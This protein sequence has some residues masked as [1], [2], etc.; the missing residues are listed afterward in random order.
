MHTPISTQL[1]PL[2]HTLSKLSNTPDDEALEQLE[3][4]RLLI[5]QCHQPELL[6]TIVDTIPS[7]IGR[8]SSEVNLALVQVAEVCPPNQLQ[9]P[10]DIDS[11]PWALRLRWLRL[12]LTKVDLETLETWEEQTLLRVVTGWSIA[13]VF[14]PEA[15]LLRCV[16]ADEPRLRVFALEQL[17]EAVIGLGIHV[18][19][20]FACLTPLLT[21]EKVS[22][23]KRAISLLSRGWLV[24]LSTKAQKLRDSVLKTALSDPS[25]K[26]VEAAVQVCCA[27]RL[28][29]LLREVMY[30]DVDDVVRACVVR[31]AGAFAQ[32]ED[33]SFVLTLALDE[34]L[35]YAAAAKSFLLEAHRHGV[36]LREEHLTDM[37]TFFDL[38]TLWEPEAWNRVMYIARKAALEELMT[39]PL[40]DPRWKRRVAL[41]TEQIDASIPSFLANS[42]SSI[43]DVELAKAFLDVAARHP[44]FVDVSTC[45]KWLDEL[46]RE[47]MLLLRLKGGEESATL[48]KHYIDEETR[49]R[50]LRRLGMS[51]LWSL[52]EDR[53]QLYRGWIE[54]FG[55][56][57]MGLFRP[58]LPQ[59][60]RD[61]VAQAV[62][63]QSWEEHEDDK[64]TPMERLRVFCKS[65][66]RHYLKEVETLFRGIFAS[67]V[68]KA[69][70]GDFSIKRV[71]IPEL[72]QM[73]FRYGRS[74]IQNGWSVRRWHHESPET[75]KDLLWLFVLDWLYE[76]PSA[77]MTVALL[78]VFVR[79]QPTGVVLRLI[80]PYWRH[81]HTNVQRAALEAII[82]GGEEA[83][84]LELSLCQLTQDTEPR[85]V[86][87]ALRALGVFQARWAE[88][89][90]TQA[91]QHP[92]M[93]VKKEAAIALAEV[94]SGQSVES[95]VFWLAYHDNVSFRSLLKLALEQSAGEAYG[96]VLLKAYCEE[97]T[98]RR[99]D[100]L[101]QAMDGA[102]RTSA[103]M[104]L[105]HKGSCD[106]LVEDCLQ[107][108]VRLSDASHVEL[109]RQLY[110]ARLLPQVDLDDPTRTMRLD[111]FSPEAARELLEL[112]EKETTH[113]GNIDALIREQFV[114][115]LAWLRDEPSQK[116]AELLLSLAKPRHKDL[117]EGLLD[118]VSLYREDLSLEVIF[119]FLR[120]CLADDKLPLPLR[121]KGLRLLRSLPVSGDMTGLQRYELLQSLGGVIELSDLRV[122]LATCR[123]APD[124]AHE[125]FALLSKAFSIP[126]ERRGEDESLTA[127]REEAES[128]YRWEEARASEWLEHTAEL[129]PLGVAVVTPF[130]DSSG[131]GD[132]SRK[133][134]YDRMV[135][136]LREG[137]FQERSHAAEQ[138]LSWPETRDVW[139]SLLTLYLNGEIDLRRG[140]LLKLTDCVKEWPAEPS[141][142]EAAEFFLPHIPKTLKRQ[143]AK[144]WLGVWLEGNVEIAPYLRMLPQEVLLPLCAEC[145]SKGHYQAIRLLA[146]DGSYAIR[147][148]LDEVERHAPEE[149]RSLTTLPASNEEEEPSLEDDFVDPIEG[150]SVDGLATLIREKSVEQGLAVRGIHA[151]GRH[152]ERGVDVLATFVTDPRPQVRSA[153]RRA[154][155]KHASRE[156]VLEAA[157]QALRMETRKDVI[158]SLMRTLGHRRYEPAFPLLLKNMQHKQRK[159]QQTARHLLLAWGDEIVPMVRHEMRRARPDVRRFYE[160]FLDELSVDEADQQP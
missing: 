160:S 7:S 4:L 45:T 34:P 72:E 133:E 90:A 19:E 53:G 12:L 117:F 138:L 80:E 38:Y 68:K 29:S 116:R 56:T 33:L 51:T 60:R 154:L 14:A 152:G 148:L 87:Q 111:G 113:K 105:A 61:E 35:V 24:G 36:F 96:A 134:R 153:A 37:L 93:A 131:G 157:T 21:D 147:C 144:E 118:I 44:F 41:L 40:H 16:R 57:E 97:T 135:K 65:G 136:L 2:L 108:Y 122:C 127:L 63:E 25:Q 121:N 52:C 46:P 70:E 104:R 140:P 126:A 50:S 55:P 141:K 78:E 81:S 30:D 119:S 137:A 76:Q 99:R 43:C 85:I 86:T 94:G 77:A 106:E 82:E 89:Y 17:E 71:C 125:T 8:L 124:V 28:G 1:Q 18:D 62:L 146:L 23:R 20:A 103:I 58:F 10:E 3:A 32:D 129:R 66:E 95:L 22:I 49:P 139:E 149:L 11:L 110:R 48:L 142:W 98:P 102:L 5:P 155:R 69:L 27:L 88:S 26:V 156:R 112:R 130:V 128:W 100:L 132:V 9:I 84:G 67:Y 13:S 79:H 74:L 75:G 151:L 158:C 15:I 107:G 91:L 115:W 123:L 83:R 114:Q 47:V 31:S 59:A 73:I 109:Q 143:F 64:I 39:L 6:E 101:A 92:S 145:I 120:R 54:R 150:K 159:I 42:L